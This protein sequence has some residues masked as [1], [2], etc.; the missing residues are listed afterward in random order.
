MAAAGIGEER[1][2]KLSRRGDGRKAWDRNRLAALVAQANYG[3]ELR[4]YITAYEI[5][6]FSGRFR[7][8]GV[9]G[10]QPTPL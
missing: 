5:C 6:R 4:Y 9:D 7:A 3:V 8:S 1:I 2:R 10:R